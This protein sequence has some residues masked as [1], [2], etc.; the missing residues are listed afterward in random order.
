[1]AQWD[2]TKKLRVIIQSKIRFLNKVSKTLFKNP[3]K[4]S[5]SQ[6]GIII[7]SINVFAHVS[8]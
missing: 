3:D 1:M 7:I 2:F 8:L 6:N 4:Q 5:N